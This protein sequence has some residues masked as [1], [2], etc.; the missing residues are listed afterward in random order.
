MRGVSLAQ[1]A[2][3]EAKGYVT[4]G[5][6]AELLTI[7]RQAVAKLCDSGELRHVRMGRRRY[8]ELASIAKYA[9]PDA[10]KLLGIAV[11]RKR[12][13]NSARIGQIIRDG[14]KPRQ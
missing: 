2:S 14:R 7:P 6:A 9:G 12:V 8:V 3:M 11:P 1:V 13:R 5:R 10:A 4:A